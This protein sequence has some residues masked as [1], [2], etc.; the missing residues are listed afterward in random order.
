MPETDCARV[1]WHEKT[2]IDMAECKRHPG[3][4][5]GLAI[6]KRIVEWHGG[7]IWVDSQPN[8][9]STFYLTIPDGGG[10]ERATSGA[11]AGLT[12]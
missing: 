6:C 8:Q 2:G 5:I 9:D 4:G 10:A 12:Q 3:T 1:I 11:A 7:N